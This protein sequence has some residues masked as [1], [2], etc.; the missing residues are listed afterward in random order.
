MKKE[1]RTE[2]QITVL[3]NPNISNSI[4]FDITGVTIGHFCS[5]YQTVTFVKIPPFVIL[6]E[7]VFYIPNQPKGKK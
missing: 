7:G 5:E 6:A 3:S 1:T 4:T 2:K